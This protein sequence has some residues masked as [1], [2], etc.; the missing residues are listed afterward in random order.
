MKFGVSIF[1]THFGASAIAIA[2]EAEKQGF[3]SFFVSE[4]SHIPVATE[5]TKRPSDNR[6][7]VATALAQLI[8][9]ARYGLQQPHPP[10]LVAGAGPNILKRVVSLGDGWLP[11]LAPQWDDSL[12][13][14]LTPLDALPEM[15]DQTRRLE[16]ELGR[17]RTT[18]TAMGLTPTHEFVDVLEENG[19]E[20]MLLNLAND[21]PKQAFEQLHA[22]GDSI[23]Q[24]E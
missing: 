9:R 18:I 12:S 7:S 8:R 15:V 4:H 22:Y 3:E 10:I 13:N 24:Y 1:P 17:T 23:K 6:S 21:N 19:V 5:Y 20:R 14:K 11:V 16:D 2:I